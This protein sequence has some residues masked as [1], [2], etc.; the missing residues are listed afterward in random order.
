MNRINRTM[1]SIMAVA[2]LI[3]SCSLCCHAN[4]VGVSTN[5]VQL[6]SASCD[7]L[8]T[9]GFVFAGADA[10]SPGD[11][12]LPASAVASAQAA[13]TLTFFGH[14][15][16]AFVEFQFVEIIFAADGGGA[17]AG[18]TANGQS[19]LGSRF[20]ITF[21]VPFSFDMFVSAA[22]DLSG[23]VEQGHDEESVGELQLTDI[24]VV[25]AGGHPLR[26]IR[27]TSGS[28]TVYPL[29]AANTLPS[30]EP[31]SLP[32]LGFGLIALLLAAKIIDAR[33]TLDG[34]MD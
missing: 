6:G 9:Y 10:I 28:G 16:H 24:L 26:S 12:N 17:G 34:A 2:F 11:P 23:D 25:N 33:Q 3:L 5:C 31:S 18:A 22:E 29:D 19:V 15:G 13:D 1:L 20:A 27:L 21:G 4:P 30:P 14:A 7:V 8:A 32:L